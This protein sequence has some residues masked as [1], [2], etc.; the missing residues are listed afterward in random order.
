MPKKKS[1]FIAV[2]FF[3]AGV[4][5]A[6]AVRLM[7]MHRDMNHAAHIPSPPQV[8]FNILH[9]PLQS[10]QGDTTSLA[11]MI[12]GEETVLVNFWATW[13]APCLH[14]MP[15]LQA[16]EAQHGIRT[17]GISY[18]DTAVIKR[19]LAQMP[20]SYA[21]YQSSFDIFYFFQQEGNRGGVMPYTVLINADGEVT[22][23]KLGDFKTVQEIADFAQG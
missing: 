12:N 20:V 2:I 4:L 5:V 18:E 14:E 21:L 23:Q 3:S 9:Q 16:A 19:F 11:E 7:P 10:L 13:C 6:V 15:L 8:E 22:R 1:L 17:I